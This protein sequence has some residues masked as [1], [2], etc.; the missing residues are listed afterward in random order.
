MEI[1]RAGIKSDPTI[2]PAERARLVALIKTGGTSP[3]NSGK[4]NGPRIYQR[5]E[6]ARLAG[7]SLRWIDS[8]ARRGLVR[9]VKLPGNI[10]AVGILAADLERLVQTSTVAAE[11]ARHDKQNLH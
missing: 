10:R 2:T 6:A 11:G 1:I 9:R 7:R 8:I 3:D 4:V 5:R